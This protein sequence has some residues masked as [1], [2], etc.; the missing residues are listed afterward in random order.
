V[1]SS[2]DDPAS[3]ALAGIAQA[4]VAGWQAAGEPAGQPPE[5]R[6]PRTDRQG[7][8]RVGV[9]AEDES[10]L[11]A[12]VA[13]HFGHA[14]VVTVIEIREGKVTTVTPVVNPG[15]ASHQPGQVPRFLKGLDVDVV[16]TG[17]M[18]ERA[19]S[20]F[21]AFGIRVVG[22]AEGTVG[23]ALGAWLRGD[24][25]AWVPCSSHGHG[26]DGGCG[27]HAHEPD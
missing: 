22:G 25:A 1:S 12:A 3:R 7:V 5:G 4:I 16:L 8:V 9:T 11:D 26:A 14:P 19:K 27:G 21:D 6:D 17:S 18:G 20:M 23:R 15:A 24:L 10:G 13:V 2:P